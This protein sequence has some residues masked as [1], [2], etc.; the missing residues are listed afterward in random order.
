MWNRLHYHRSDFS[1]ERSWKSQ[2]TVYW[3]T[4][5]HRIHFYHF[6][7]GSINLRHELYREN[8]TV[9]RIIRQLKALRNAFK[10]LTIDSH[11]HYVHITRSLLSNSRR[12]NTHK[13]LIRT[14]VAQH[15]LCYY[16]FFSNYST[17]KNSRAV[18]SL[19]LTENHPS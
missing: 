4:D 15:S 13:G 18:T 12:S 14:V 17:A 3:R 9:I 19:E 10:M 16:L 2:C 7:G 1:P 6:L 11:S 5:P 8:Q